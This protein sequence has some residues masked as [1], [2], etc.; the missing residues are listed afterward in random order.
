MA[1]TEN[2]FLKSDAVNP[3]VIAHRGFSAAYP[4]NTRLAFDAAVACGIDAME[5]D[6]QWTRDREVLCFHDRS[7][8]KLGL[9][10]HV[11]RNRNFSELGTL[12]VGGWFDGKFSDQRLL[13]LEDVLSGYG[14]KTWLLLEIKRRA[15]RNDPGQ[16]HALMDSVLAQVESHGLGQRVAILCFDEEALRRG[17]LSYPGIRFVLNQER[18]RILPDDAHLAA[19]SVRAKNLTAG[20]VE[21]VHAREK[22]VMVFTVNDRALLDRMLALGVD[23]IM[24]DNPAWLGEALRIKS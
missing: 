24:S 4:E 23:G 12:D 13:R 3:W 17:W 18:P 9:G 20:F 22:P 7:L 5:L 16:L 1:Q 8:H 2:P 21:R 10:R 14:H 15:P 6:L 11:M 19:Y